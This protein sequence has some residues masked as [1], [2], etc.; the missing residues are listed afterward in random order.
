VAAACGGRPI[1]R[2]LPGPIRAGA[3]LPLTHRRLRCDPRGPS[4]RRGRAGPFS[5]IRAGLYNLTRSLSGHRGHDRRSQ[6]PGDDGM[7]VRLVGP[8]PTSDGQVVRL[9]ILLCRA[10]AQKLRAPL[11]AAMVR[12]HVLRHLPRP[13]RYA[14]T[15]EDDGGNLRFMRNGR[16]LATLDRCGS[17]EWT[18]ARPPEGTPPVGSPEFEAGHARFE[19]GV[20]ALAIREA[21]RPI[22]CAGRRRSRVARPRARARRSPRASR[23]PPSS[24]DDPDPEPAGGAQLDDEVATRA[25]S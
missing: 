18:K 24:D 19:G 5:A 7:A 1:A 16:P 9:L 15:V 20:R 8:E 23:A 14:I 11:P 12:S 10:E 4:L 6:H 2:Y 25:A 3:S 22:G 21:R 17:L 13:L